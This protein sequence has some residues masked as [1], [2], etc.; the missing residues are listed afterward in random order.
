METL[1]KNNKTT[2]GVDKKN[3][4]SSE[5]DRYGKFNAGVYLRKK[6]NLIISIRSTQVYIIPFNQIVYIDSAQNANGNWCCIHTVG[7]NHNNDKE[8]K[9]QT[10]SH[11]DNDGKHHTS[12]EIPSCTIDAAH[13]AIVQQLGRRRNPFYRCGKLYVINVDYLRFIDNSNQKLYLDDGFKSYQLNLPRKVF[14]Q[15]VK[16]LI[17]RDIFKV[18]VD[19][20][21]KIMHGG[22][23][24]KIKTVTKNSRNKSLTD[25]IK[26]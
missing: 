7:Q 6:D 12:W 21:E 25:P 22:R 20:L 19:F 4:D 9:K 15:M 3:E 11:T 8:G 26:R 2:T 18:I 5:L 13:Q 16:D 24:K 23:P 1:D 17:K 10:K 14:T